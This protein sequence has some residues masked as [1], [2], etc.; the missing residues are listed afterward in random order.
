MI[1]HKMWSERHAWKLPVCGPTL[2]W[3][4]A[5]LHLSAV[6]KGRLWSVSCWSCSICLHLSHLFPVAA[7]QLVIHS[8]ESGYVVKVWIS[9]ETEH[10]DYASKFK[11]QPVGMAAAPLPLKFSCGFL[12]EVFG[13][14][15]GMADGRM[16]ECG[17]CTR[18]AQ[19]C[20]VHC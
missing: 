10:T 15:W 3:S 9:K 18:C 19:L 11:S 4:L 5:N 20:V 16:R 6:W 8:S 2:S 13:K 12:W 1:C 7:N 14:G 17:L